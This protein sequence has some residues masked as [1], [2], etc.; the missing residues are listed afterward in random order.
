M[1]ESFFNRVAR[2]TTLLKRNS[3]TGVFLWILQN[4]SEHLFGRI[5]ANDNHYI[6]QET[7]R[8]K[9]SNYTKNELFHR[10]FCKTVLKFS[11]ILCENFGTVK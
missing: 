8:L 4:V 1:L 5:F 9:A 10:L 2:A 7:W 6:F 11:L 3:N